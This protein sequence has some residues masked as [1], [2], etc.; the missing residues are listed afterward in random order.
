VPLQLPAADDI[1]TV[2]VPEKAS[3]ELKL[4]LVVSSIRIVQPSS[5]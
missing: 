2:S 4:S 3:S 1:V 5:T